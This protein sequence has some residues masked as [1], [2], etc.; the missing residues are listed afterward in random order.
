MNQ[1][2]VLKF[3]FS[4]YVR[5]S[6]CGVIYVL[7]LYCATK[8]LDLILSVLREND[9]PLVE[10][11]ENESS[12]F[13]ALIG[14]ELKSDIE[15]RR[16]FWRVVNSNLTNMDPMPSVKVFIHAAQS[17]Y[18][19]TEGSVDGATQDRALLCSSTAHLK[20]KTCFK[21]LITQ[22]VNRLIGLIMDQREDLL[23]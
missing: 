9:S 15:S 14:N 6:E 23:Q 12:A 13:P 22:P 19:K 8:H 4:I 18:S 5:A 2:V 21:T 3:N 16:Q 17:L 1:M 7:I 20:W 10:W 11:V